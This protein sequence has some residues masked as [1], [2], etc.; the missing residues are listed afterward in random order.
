MPTGLLSMLILF[1][2]LSH[3][4]SYS[5]SHC[6]ISVDLTSSLLILLPAKN[7][8]VESLFHEVFISVTVLFGSGISVCGSFF[9]FYLLMLLFCTY[10][11][12]PI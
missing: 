7:S 3:T 6:T 11:V 5:F 2:L 1:I 10:I 8:A 9:D 4:F 12:F